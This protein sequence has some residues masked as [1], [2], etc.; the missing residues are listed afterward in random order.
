MIT[1]NEVIQLIDSG[2]LA[3]DIVR[4]IAPEFYIKQIEGLSELTKEVV[5]P[6]IKQI[7]GLT[8]TKP[9]NTIQIK[10]LTNTKPIE[11][12]KTKPLNTKKNKGLSQGLSQDSDLEEQDFIRTLRELK[13]E[14]KLQEQKLQNQ[15]AKASKTN[16]S[17]LFVD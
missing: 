7:E 1:A 13:A 8:K 9:L 6:E 10:E 2:K 5:R 14:Q 12:S 17:N 11:T 15:E 3:D 4:Y 16:N